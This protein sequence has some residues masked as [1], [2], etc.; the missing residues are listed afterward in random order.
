MRV[1]RLLGQVHTVEQAVEQGIDVGGTERI[2][3]QPHGVRNRV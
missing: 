1:R 3:R 2:E